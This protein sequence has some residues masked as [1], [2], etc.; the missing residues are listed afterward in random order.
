VRRKLGERPKGDNLPPLAQIHVAAMRF[1]VPF[2]SQTWKQPVPFDV[3]L[4]VA[5]NV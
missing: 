3:K 2:P 5:T 1:L 4:K